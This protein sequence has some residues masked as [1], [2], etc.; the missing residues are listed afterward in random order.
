MDT[1]KGAEVKT[2]APFSHRQSALR[3]CSEPDAFRGRGGADHAAPQ[4]LEEPRR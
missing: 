1:L 3:M 4:K 2:S